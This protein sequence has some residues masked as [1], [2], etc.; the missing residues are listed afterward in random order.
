[1]QATEAFP[2]MPRLRADQSFHE[3][4]EHWIASSSAST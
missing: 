3:A 1:M 4:K 2:E